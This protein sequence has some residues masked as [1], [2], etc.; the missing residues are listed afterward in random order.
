MPLFPP[1]TR[2]PGKGDARIWGVVPEKQGK[3]SLSSRGVKEEE[4][5]RYYSEKRMFGVR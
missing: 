3:V 2:Q 1:V 4:R 5:R